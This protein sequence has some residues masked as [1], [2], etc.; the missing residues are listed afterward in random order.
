ML[1][2]LGEVYLNDKLTDEILIDPCR[3]TCIPPFTKTD[4]SPLVK[5]DGTEETFDDLFDMIIHFDNS[6]ITVSNTKK[7]LEKIKSDIIYKSKGE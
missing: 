3:V 6:M 7:K 1:F 5:H 4:K 2:N